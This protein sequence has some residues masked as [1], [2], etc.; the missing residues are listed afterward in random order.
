MEY[1]YILLLENIENDKDQFVCLSVC[2]SW[3]R[4]N[5]TCVDI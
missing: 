5:V 1:I 2:L 3:F 4:Q